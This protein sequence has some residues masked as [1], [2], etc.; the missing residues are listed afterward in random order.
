[1]AIW[2]VIVPYVL[3]ARELRYIHAAGEYYRRLRAGEVELDAKSCCAVGMFVNRKEG[4]LLIRP[5]YCIDG[6]NR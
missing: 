2:A 5:P 1:M 4:P 6:E 3:L